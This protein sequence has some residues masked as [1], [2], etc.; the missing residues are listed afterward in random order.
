MRI[1]KHSG[2]KLDWKPLL[3]QALGSGL[4]GLL[5][6]LVLQS[7]W[8]AALGAA[9]G[10]ALCALIVFPIGRI[11]RR[12]ILFMAL[13]LAFTAASL[14]VL[15]WGMSALDVWFETLTPAQQYWLPKA[16]MAISGLLAALGAFG[17]YRSRLRDRDPT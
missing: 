4:G 17:A 6:N 13:A 3:L 7:A 11:L 15:L 8:G 5:G 16:G 2:R 10:V 9:L 14:A 12:Q 1:S